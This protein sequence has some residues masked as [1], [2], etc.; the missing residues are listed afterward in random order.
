MSHGLRAVSR[1][2]AVVLGLAAAGAAAA[3]EAEPE[4]DR[5]GRF[6]LEWSLEA[7]AHFRDSDDERHPLV[8]LALPPELRNQA[9]ATVDPGS[10]LE[11]STVT[12]HLDATLGDSLA[13]GL[14]LDFIDLYDRNP[15]STG[16]EW[17]VDEAWLRFGREAEPA[18]PPEDPSAYLKV[19]KF[20]KFERQD[21]RHLES[22]GLVST[23]F[24]RFEDTGVELGV[25]L[26]RFAYVKA[27]ATQGNPL[28]MRDPNALAGDNGLRDQ[29]LLLRTPELG[30]GFV[31]PYDA[32]GEDLDTDGDVQVGVG[33]GLRFGRPGGEDGF[34]LLAFGRRRDLAPV[35]EFDGT[36]YGGDLDL[37]NGPGDAFPFPV[38]SDQKE[39]VGGTAWLYLGGFTLFAQYVDQDLGGLART[40]AEAELAWRFELPVGASV[41]GRQL[42]PSIQPAVRW[43]RLDPD[44]LP[45]AGGPTPSFAW[46][47]E[48][49]DWGVRLGIVEGIDLTA[50]YADHTMTLTSGAERSNDELLVTLRWR[51]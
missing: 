26:G 25:D 30:S 22:Y 41:G 19:G 16:D 2:A 6:E 35:V 32:E 13:A 12:L 15:T 31:I 11:L 43:S 29:L 20:P 4:G 34:E 37:L 10:H 17:D 3:E 9:L 14:K 42:F 18:L 28:F 47:W 1:L 33:V 5:A 8:I 50:E 21:D 27:S 51:T 24:N 49:I 38:T 40:G 39:E 45:P 36:L 48:K 7:K 46:D 44:F 23:A